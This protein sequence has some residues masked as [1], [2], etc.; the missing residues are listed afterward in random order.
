M[1]TF[2]ARMQVKPGKEAEFED[3][4][5]QLTENGS[6]RRSTRMLELNGRQGAS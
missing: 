3:L 1:M 2:I 4:A 6:D 5:K